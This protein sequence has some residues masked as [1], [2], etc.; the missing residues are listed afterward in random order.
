MNKKL[1][2]ETL[3][4]VDGHFINAGAHIERLRQTVHEAYGFTPGFSLSDLTIPLHQRQGVVKCRIEYGE[5]IH[6][7]SFDEYTPR[8]I[9]CLKLVEG[10]DIDYH[11]K[12]ADRSL[13][14]DLLAQRGDCDDILIVCHGKI[15]DTSYSNVILYDGHNYVTPSSYLLNGVKRQELINNGIIKEATVTIHDLKNYSHLCLINAMLDPE[16]GIQVDVKNI[17]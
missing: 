12:Y 10:R 11:L 16:N 14:T 13:L 1:F 9:R 5:S 15:T 3:K 8:T 4:V 17:R 2:I 7:I 6:R